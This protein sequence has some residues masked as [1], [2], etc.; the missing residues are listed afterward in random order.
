M[1]NGEG[2]PVDLFSLISYFHSPK[3]NNQFL[4]N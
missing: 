4:D 1:V 3:L 2:A